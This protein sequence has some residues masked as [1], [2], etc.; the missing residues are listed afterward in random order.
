MLEALKCFSCGSD[1]DEDVSFRQCPKC[2]LDL[3]LVCES[4]QEPTTSAAVLAAAHPVLTDFQILERIGRGGVGVVYRA[5]PISR[6]RIVALKV[7][8]AQLDSP[9]ALGPFFR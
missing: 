8:G 9:T 1:I 5:R 3:A 4:M 6:N 2:L 7:I